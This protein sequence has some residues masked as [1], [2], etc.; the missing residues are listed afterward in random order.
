VWAG[1]RCSGSRVRRLGWRKVVHNRR[2]LGLRN[3][4][5][6]SDN[7]EY[8]NISSIEPRLY[9]LARLIMDITA[10]TAGQ[11]LAK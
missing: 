1:G 11:A 5:A 9:L 2:S 10:G 3:F 7:A 6:H 4:G 8:V